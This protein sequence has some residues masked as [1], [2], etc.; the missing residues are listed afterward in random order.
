MLTS[1]ILYADNLKLSHVYHCKQ[2]CLPEFL[3]DLA[4]FDVSGFVNFG[5]FIT[6]ILFSL[7]KY[8]SA[9]F[10]P[11]LRTPS[12]FVSIFSCLDQI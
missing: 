1:L 2:K 10:K 3:T 9:E 5:S 7:S 11:S 6:I 12:K 8:D 4:N